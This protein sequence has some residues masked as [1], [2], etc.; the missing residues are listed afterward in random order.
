MTG[1]DRATPVVTMAPPPESEPE[2]IR[3]VQIITTLARGGAQATVLGSAIMAE[4]GVEVTVLAGDE[5]W[6]EGDYW[7]E[8]RA[9]GIR[10]VA[11]P[12]LRRRPGPVTD[13]RA[14]RHLVRL[15]RQ[16]DPD[17]VHTHSAK[18]GVLG[19]V[20]ARLVRVPL[21][22]T[23]HGWGP[24]HARSSTV[25]RLATRVER[26]LARITEVLVVV[27]EDD[28]EL[29]AGAGIGCPE[30]YRLIRSGIELA[31]LRSDPGGRVRAR[32]ELGLGDEF[33]FG[34][35]ARMAGQKD[36]VGLV[37]AFARAD[38]GSAVLVLIGDGA[39][40]SEVE[41]AVERLG[42]AGRVRFVGARSDAGQLV[43]AFDVSVLASWYEGMPRTVLEAVALGVPVIAS[44]V[45]SVGRLIEN[46]VSGRLVPAGDRPA[47]A[48][49][50]RDA[51]DRPEASARMAAAA[52]A[53][54]DE[55]SA[56]RMRR[57]LAALWL[58]VARSGG[59]VRSGATIR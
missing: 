29:G 49:A 48:A 7:A 59:R 15:L 11:V 37:E 3:V 45:G 34:M 35:V 53:R 46:G 33:T 5:T 17:V 27:G 50:L 22:H 12:G 30:R 19:R 31:D 14:L 42:I 13:A 47:L 36:H 39:A 18:A 26:T 40:R 16:L 28:R 56:D 10:V 8:A 25:V 1:I 41:A 44:D 51:N 24:L 4:H 43:A 55:F 6:S 21:V 23:V 58:E 9:A 20:A 57:D 32:S 38:L 54:I 2:P 52:S